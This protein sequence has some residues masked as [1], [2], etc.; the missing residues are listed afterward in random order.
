MLLTKGRKMKNLLVLAIALTAI[1][2][3][4]TRARVSALA[5]SPHLID[6]QTVYNNPADVH[7]LGADWVTLETGATSV[8]STTTGSNAEGMIVRSAGDVKY[9]LSLGHRS[10]NAALSS[11]RGG[12]SLVT[13]PATLK[14]DQQ[15]PVELTYGA[16]SGDMGWAGTLIYSNF[17]DKVNDIKESSAGVR[18]GARAANWDGALRIGLTNTVESLAAGKFTGTTSIGLNGGYTC[19]NNVYWTGA[20]TTTGFKLENTAGTETGKV[21][22]NEIKLGAMTSVKKDG[23]EFFYGA[24]LVQTD[25][26]QATGTEVK[27]TST[28]LPLFIGVETEASSWLTLRGSVTQTLQLLNSDKTES[29]GVTASETAPGANDTTVAAGAGLKFNKVNVDGTL[30]AATSQQLNSTSLL[31]QVG[32]TYSF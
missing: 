7:W 11:L 24:S 15:N 3:Q 20:I 14:L 25:A 31:A 17:N 28:S 10:S 16:K 18:F 27:V 1:N 6:T 13:I 29:G 22:A 9:G 8:S 30:T 26:K 23:A 2:A 5:N 19:S 32:M 12:L 21:T 4:A